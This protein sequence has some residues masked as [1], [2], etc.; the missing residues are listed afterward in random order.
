MDIWKYHLA[1]SPLRRGYEL[2]VETLKLGHFG[3]SSS[4]VAILRLGNSPSNISTIP[5]SLIDKK[6]AM[7][8]TALL[9]A[10]IRGDYLMV[11]QLLQRG[12]DPDIGD[13]RKSAPLHNCVTESSGLVLAALINAV[14]AL[15][16]QDC[17]GRI[18]LME[19]IRCREYDVEVLQKCFGTAPDDDTS[20]CTKNGNFESTRS[21]NDATN[22]MPVQ[23]QA[24]IS[25]RPIYDRTPLMSTPGAKEYKVLRHLLDSGANYTLLDNDQ[26][27]ILHVA[28]DYGDIECLRVLRQADLRYLCV[29][30][31]N[32]YGYT[33]MDIAT[34]RKN[35]NTKWSRW[36]I[37]APDPHPEGWYSEFKN[38]C[39]NIKSS[40]EI[41][42][43]R[44]TGT[45]CGSLGETLNDNNREEYKDCNPPGS[46][47]HD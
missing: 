9:W 42:Q 40:Q 37:R 34:W 8:R 4:H 46:F 23:N 19:V 18:A 32:K 38:L 2:V 1:N 10:T 6:D 33:P 47:P 28:A 11:N 17:L 44:S 26:R 21:H 43:P 24:G 29:D 3:F 20:K 31:Q 27:S 30:S 12:A 25:T 45:G 5:R 39:T 15:D 16:L 14:A 35:D 13:T 36:A 7:G 22:D 41:L